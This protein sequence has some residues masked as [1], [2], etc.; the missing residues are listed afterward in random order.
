MEAEALAA[1]GFKS[2]QVALGAMR[3][4]ALDRPFDWF[5]SERVDLGR[6]VVQLPARDVRAQRDRL[7]R[8]QGGSR[9]QP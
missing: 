1:I 2:S 4:L 9:G 6:G 3:N 7:Q 8:G 5:R